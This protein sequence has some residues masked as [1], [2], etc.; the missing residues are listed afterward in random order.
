MRPHGGSRR[1]DIGALGVALAMALAA[2]AAAAPPSFSG[3]TAFASGDSPTAI[4]AADLNADG[5]PDLATTDLSVND[6]AGTRC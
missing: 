3:P 2:P 6:R 4:A 1:C 5:R